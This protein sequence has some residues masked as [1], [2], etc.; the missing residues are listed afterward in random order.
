MV[1]MWFLLPFFILRYPFPFI[2]FYKELKKYNINLCSSSN[3][4]SDSAWFDAIASDTPELEIIC[5]EKIGLHIYG[6]GNFPSV[7]LFSD[8]L[9][10]NIIS[11][12]KNAFAI[13]SYGN[14]TARGK[15]GSTAII[16]VTHKWGS[17]LKCYIS[18]KII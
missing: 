2:G 18:V 7:R 8:H 14:V 13:D 5:K 11:G 1:S 17:Q 10:Y 16:E 12:K 9:C 6:I 15:A 3:S 4:Y